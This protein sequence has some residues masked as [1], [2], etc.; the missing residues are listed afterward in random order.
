[1]K[2]IRG[3]W[4]SSLLFTVISSTAIYAEQPGQQKDVTWEEVRQSE[5]IPDSI[6]QNM[7]TEDLL[8]SYLDSRYPG[9]LLAYDTIQDAF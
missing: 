9:Y 3:L 7:P 4:I 6:L 2:I 5:Q 1:M 8:M